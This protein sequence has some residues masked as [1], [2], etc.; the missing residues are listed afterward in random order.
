MHTTN[1]QSLFLAGLFAFL[2]IGCDSIVAAEDT[3][4][5]PPSGEQPPPGVQLPPALNQTLT[6]D[7]A[8]DQVVLTSRPIEG[9][10]G[11][12]QVCLD[13]QTQSGWWKGLGLNMSAPSIQGESRDGLRCT[14]IDA[15]RVDIAYWKAAFLG[16]H[17]PVGTG[18]VDLSAYSDHEIVFTWTKD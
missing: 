1:M 11:R 8:K 4:T 14:T 3:N 17:T 10:A 5:P 13:V 15:G 18:R 7:D 12:M 2:V 16:I 9:L 6:T